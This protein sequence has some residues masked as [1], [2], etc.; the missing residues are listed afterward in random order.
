M[1]EASPPR[2]LSGAGRG[3]GHPVIGRQAL[4]DSLPVPPLPHPF[5]GQPGV[6]PPAAPATV[7]PTIVPALRLKWPR[8]C[9]CVWGGGVEGGVPLFG[10]AH[11]PE[12]PLRAHQW[13]WPGHTLRTPTPQVSTRRGRG[14]RPY[15]SA[16]FLQ[17]LSRA[18]VFPGRLYPCF[19]PRSLAAAFR[20]SSFSSSG[21]GLGSVPKA[22]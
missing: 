4:T 14:L 22:A 18:F 19:P 20:H 9:V 17:M 10:V 16:P 13:S 5:P 3:R 21:V 12:H 8:G 1:E 15:G 7:G 11:R 2:A 6:A